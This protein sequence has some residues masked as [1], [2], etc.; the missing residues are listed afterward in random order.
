LEIFRINKIGIGEALGIKIEKL[1]L[2]GNYSI[3]ELYSMIKH[4]KFEAGVPALVKNGFVDIIFYENNFYCY[5][6]ITSCTCA[7]GV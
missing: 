4:V 6:G 5:K 2:H 1:N 7:Y 3:E